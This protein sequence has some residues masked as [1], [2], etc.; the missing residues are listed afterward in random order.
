METTLNVQ[1]TF[2]LDK[3][4]DALGN[5]PNVRANRALQEL[6]V[7]ALAEYGSTDSYGDP[8][9]NAPQLNN[10]VSFIILESE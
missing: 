6:L 3:V 7:S 10:Y 9:F 2:H 1:V 4:N 5:T 8:I